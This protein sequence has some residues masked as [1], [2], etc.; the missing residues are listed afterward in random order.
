MSNFAKQYF[1]FLIL[2]FGIDPLDNQKVFACKSAAE[3][4]A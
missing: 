1:L 2:A 4:E 3:L